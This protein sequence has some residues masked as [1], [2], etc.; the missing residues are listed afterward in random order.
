MNNKEYLLKLT[1][2]EKKQLLQNACFFYK[3]VKQIK[4]IINLK[5]RGT[6]KE[7]NPK[8]DEY[9]E[10][11]KSIFEHILENLEPVYSLI[12][13]K[14]FLEKPKEE[15]W[16]MDYFSKSTFYKRQHE[17]IDEFINMFYG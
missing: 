15:T 4:T 8:I 6:K 14:V 1:F 12:I 9:D 3:K 10:M 16:Y 11:N 13:T 5:A 2:K 7:T 17:A